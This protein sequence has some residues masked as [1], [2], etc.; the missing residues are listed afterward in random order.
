MYSRWESL[1]VFCNDFLEFWSPWRL[2]K[3]IARLRDA[4]QNRPGDVSEAAA[5]I[6]RK[7]LSGTF[8]KRQE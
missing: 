2:R 8:Q 3:Q 6:P 5:E 4:G 7:H 1:V